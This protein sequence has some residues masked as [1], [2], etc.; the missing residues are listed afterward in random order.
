M[1]IC[2]AC[3]T[4]AAEGT[5]FCTTCGRTV[6]EAEA[7]PAPPFVPRVGPIPGRSAAPP[8]VTTIAAPAAEWLPPELEG[9]AVHCVRC[10]SIISAVAVVCPVCLAR[11]PPVGA[12]VAVSEPPP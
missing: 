3:G 8:V 6:V 4:P 11:Q 12:G 5:L 10:N 2:P 7:R 1:L 9:R